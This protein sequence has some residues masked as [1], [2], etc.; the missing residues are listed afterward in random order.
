MTVLYIAGP[1]YGLPE[2]NYPAFQQAEQW[3]VDAG[4]AVISPLEADRFVLA[5]DPEPSREWWQ[6]TTLKLML[7]CTGVALLDGWT[8]SKGAKLEVLVA[9]RLNYDVKRVDEWLTS[10]TS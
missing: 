1:M 4:F 7:N 5:G 10:P 3:L 6:R 2:K 8:N 9:K